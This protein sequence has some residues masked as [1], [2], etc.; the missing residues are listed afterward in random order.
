MFAWVFTVLATPL[1]AH[2]E[3]APVRKVVEEFLRV[4]T[5]GL[6]GQTAI[7]AGSI[8]PQNNLTP[9]PALEAFMPPGGRPWG[10]IHVGVRCQ[11]EGGWKIYVPASVSVS[12]TFLVTAKALAQ[13]Q[14]VNADDVMTR[15]GDLTQLPPGI[16][17]QTALAVGKTLALSVAAGQVLRSDM[18]K[19]SPLILQGQNVKLVSRG[20]GFQVAVDG[21]AI[22]TAA[23]GQIAQARLASGQTLSGIARADGMIEIKY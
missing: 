18:L 14:L 23:E 9:C 4:Q 21:R 2:Q 1:A 8:D 16:L 20:A 22:N 15:N 6:P 10:R 3:V 7:S 5:Q 13:G 17:S 12:G 19:Q 11:T